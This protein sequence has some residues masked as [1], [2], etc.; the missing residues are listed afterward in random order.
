MRLRPPH[1]FL[2]LDGRGRSISQVRLTYHQSASQEIT[3]SSSIELFCI[4]NEFALLQG[5]L[6]AI[7][8]PV[9]GE[10]CSNLASWSRYDALQMAQWENL[11]V[12]MDGNQEAA[13]VNPL[14]F[15]E[16][17]TMIACCKGV[18]LA[19]SDCTVPACDN[20]SLDGR[21][22]CST[23]KGK[24]GFAPTRRNPSSLLILWSNKPM[25]R[26]LSSLAHSFRKP[27]L[28]SEI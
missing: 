11:M 23:Y 7:Q 27:T 22:L 12:E 16:E 17:R 26:M 3:V 14:T 1:R 10:T 19:R 4:R 24:Y 18:P 8:T 9:V 13:I 28:W 25:H 15:A 21:G 5:S 2:T 6:A 20:P